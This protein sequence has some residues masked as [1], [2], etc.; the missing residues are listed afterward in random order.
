MGG[1]P[2]AASAMLYDA[3]VVSALTSVDLDQPGL[4]GN[5]VIEIARE[6][7]DREERRAVRVGPKFPGV[8][9]VARN[10]VPEF[11]SELSGLLSSHRK[12]FVALCLSHPCLHQLS[13]LGVASTI[14]DRY[15]ESV[16]RLYGK[17]R[18]PLGVVISRTL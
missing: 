1:S 3:V 6:G 16:I 8:E 2:D 14:T 9:E 17:V 13:N 5:T 15:N 18:T 4:F 7:G 11:W 10:I 12:I